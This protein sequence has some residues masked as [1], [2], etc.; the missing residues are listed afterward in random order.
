[1][2]LDEDNGESLC[3]EFNTVLANISNSAPRSVTSSW[4]H[5]WGG[6]EPGEER[7]GVGLTVRVKAELMVRNE[8]DI[9]LL[10]ERLCLAWIDP[11][12]ALYKGRYTRHIDR[13]TPPIISLSQQSM[14]GTQSPRQVLADA[15]TSQELE[16][17]KG[18]L[19]AESVE[20]ALVSVFR[21]FDVDGNGFLSRPEIA[22]IIGE[23]CTE[24]VVDRVLLDM[25]G[26]EGIKEGVVTLSQFIAYASSS[27][28]VCIGTSRSLPSPPT[29]PSPPSLP[30]QVLASLVGTAQEQEE[31]L[32][33]IQA[34]GYQSW[35]GIGF[36]SVQE[37]E[38]LSQ[39]ARM[40]FIFS[41]FDRDKS[42][43]LDRNEIKSIIGADCTDSVVDS[44]L[45][46]M[47]GNAE[48]AGVT[49]QDFVKYTKKKPAV[50][51]M[52]SQKAINIVA[53]SCANN[54]GH[55]A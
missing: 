6:T 4:K 19:R 51:E 8:Q 39:D 49:V 12:G 1:V 40:E 7:Q 54:Q 15:L 45:A 42:G 21:Q 41:V 30:L 52:F 34:N 26:E 22:T 46:D 55:A 28:Q 37:V 27:P 24:E 3:S 2:Q 11:E 43:K 36:R 38:S 9:S 10:R 14:G 23:G 48:K 32:P 13:K 31:Q 53:F 17:L 25:A 44:V 20:T 16:E 33:I 18:K 5:Y 29:A 35:S 47:V 50:A